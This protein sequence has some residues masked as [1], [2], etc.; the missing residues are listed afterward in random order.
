MLLVSPHNPTGHAIDADERR[1]L[2][3][4]DVPLVVDEVFADFAPGHRT[5]ADFDAGLCFTLSGLSKVAGLPQLKLGWMVVSGPERE[6]REAL[7]RL[8]HLA[9]A[10]L[11][12]A[13][14]VQLALPALLAGS[15]A[16]RARVQARLAQNRAAL[17]A[18]RPADA[19]WDVLL[20]A[21]WSAAV[22]VP[23]TRTQDG[24]CAALL[25]AG[26]VVQPGHLFDLTSPHAL[27]LS[28]LPE[29]DDFA[30]AAARLA[31]VL[32]AQ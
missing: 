19:T 17:E 26:V 2:G 22:A 8:E 30:R 9:D 10:F 18:T 3:G 11:S 12:V 13:T 6:R 28:L 21:G 24:W 31:E 32:A 1:R 5:M 16:F 14:P 15:D 29:P 4:L 7:E 20:G 23:R 25:E 27:V